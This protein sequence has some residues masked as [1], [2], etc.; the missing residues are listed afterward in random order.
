VEASE[1]AAAGA[2]EKA[3]TASDE[4]QPDEEAE[5]QVTA[6]SGLG[7][8]EAAGAPE[9]E[10]GSKAEAAGS[11]AE[12][13]GSNAEAVAPEA[14]S[15]D[16]GTAGGSA[17]GDLP[18]EDCRVTAWSHPGPCSA[19]CDGGTAVRTRN[20]TTAAA[21]GGASCP[22]LSEKVSCNTY[23]CRLAVLPGGE[24]VVWPMPR[25]SVALASD[26]DLSTWT[27][28]TAPWCEHSPFWVGL[29]FPQGA[30]VS[31]LR[32][33]KRHHQGKGRDCGNKH[34]EVVYSTDSADVP[35]GRRDYMRVKDLTNGYDGMEMWNATHVGDV[36]VQG[37][38]H[39]SERGG[40]ASLTFATVNATSIAL[41]VESADPSY[42]HFCL[43]EMQALQDLDAALLTKQLITPDGNWAAI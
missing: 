28:S 30:L 10:A 2:S 38:S 27:Y 24:A 20:V 16:V 37:D 17:L 43:A 18:A 25:N 26:G 40:W 32:V 39:D 14:A 19:K 5:E 34:L 11:N 41:Q 6:G 35:V 31:G 21:N 29:S 23:S 7:D 33:W 15:S 8:A 4:A 9:P 3:A 12:A 42:N 22:A 36:K 13:A 1:A